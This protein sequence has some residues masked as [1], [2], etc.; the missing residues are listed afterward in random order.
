MTDALPP[1]LPAAALPAPV[2]GND[3]RLKQALVMSAA[4]PAQPGTQPAVVEI[5][6]ATMRVVDLFTPPRGIAGARCRWEVDGAAREQWF[7]VDRLE[8]VPA[9]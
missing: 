5:P 8:V 3:V 2:I 9:A 6:R 4:G 7:A 1:M